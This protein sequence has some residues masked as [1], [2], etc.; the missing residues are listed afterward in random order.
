MLADDV[1]HGNVRRCNRELGDADDALILQAAVQVRA[2]LLGK[3][4]VL[5]DNERL[6]LFLENGPQGLRSAFNRAEARSRIACD[7]AV[8][9]QLQGHGAGVHTELL[10]SIVIWPPRRIDDEI[11]LE[12][13]DLE[14]LLLLGRHRKR[15]QGQ[16]QQATP[17]HT[18][19]VYAVIGPPLA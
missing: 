11:R 1:P 19:L 15:R 13:G 18:P 7:A 9:L 10:Q 16:R 4:R 12:R 3:G 14:R 8:G 5:A 2:D 17:V 6:H